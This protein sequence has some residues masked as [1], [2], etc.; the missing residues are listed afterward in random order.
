M[1]DDAALIAIIHDPAV[2][3]HAVVRDGKDVG[4]L[5]L[6]FRKPGLCNLVYVA[7]LPEL[8]GQGHGRWLLARASALA[9]RPDVGRVAVHTCTLDH[10]AALPA[11]RRA[12]FVETGRAIETFPDPR[13]AGWLDPGDAPRIALLS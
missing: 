8:T 6:D 12:G 2:S 5:E 11:Y 4:L 9:W 13:I 10:P 7:L 3:V 1:L